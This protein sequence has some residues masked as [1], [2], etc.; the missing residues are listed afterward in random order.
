MTFADDFAL[1]GGLA[2]APEYPTIFGVSIS[3][4]VGGV[5]LALAGLAGGAAIG[6]YMVKPAW[7]NLQA[8]ETELEN[9]QSQIERLRSAQQ[10]ISRLVAEQQQLEVQKQEILSLFAAQDK[11]DTYLYDFARQIEARRGVLVKFIPAAA[12]QGKPAD[13]EIVQD[14]SWGD[15]ANGLLQTRKYDVAMEGTFDQTQS[16]IR[17]I[18]A[19]QL[20]SAVK[21]FSSQ[22]KE[23]QVLL[24]DPAKT[25]FIP[26]DKPKLATTFTLE[27]LVPRSA[28]ELEEAAK[29]KQGAKAAPA[30]GGAQPSPA[31]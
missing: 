31:K 22:V 5:L 4:T 25:A 30:A 27:T 10:E 2:E 21:N 12:E 7:E 16:I 14:G 13:S 29:A 26:L 1:E 20:L 18:E 3:P 24:Y 6:W 9:V 15:A 19:L 11:E 8:K 28:K 23:E 17:S